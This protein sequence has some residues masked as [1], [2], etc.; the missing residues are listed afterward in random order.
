MVERLVLAKQAKME[1]A[2]N[3]EKVNPTSANGG[4]TIEDL[5]MPTAAETVAIEGV[6]T[7]TV[8]ENYYLLATREVDSAPLDRMPLKTWAIC[9][10]EST[11]KTQTCSCR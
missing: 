5:T 7:E 11:V 4:E 10:I 2:P 1:Y 8:H 6:S 3:L 9:R